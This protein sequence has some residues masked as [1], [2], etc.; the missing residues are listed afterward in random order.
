MGHGVISF[1]AL[2]LNLL[3]TLFL[4]NVRLQEFKLSTGTYLNGVGFSQS[5]VDLIRL[6]FNV[7][8]QI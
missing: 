5:N 8:I 1:E 3:L 6:F 2:A 4:S 7:P